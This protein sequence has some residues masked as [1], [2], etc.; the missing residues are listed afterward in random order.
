MKFEKPLLA[1]IAV[2]ETI[3]TAD[4]QDV[5]WGVGQDVRHAPWP[6]KVIK[7]PEFLAHRMSVAANLRTD[8]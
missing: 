3:R 6:C 5:P 2:T 7:Q 4:Q 1:P 8:Q